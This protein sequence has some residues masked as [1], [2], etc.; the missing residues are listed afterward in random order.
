MV[1]VEPYG[2]NEAKKLVQRVLT[3]GTV[4]I[5]KHCY[6]RLAEHK[7]TAVDITNTLRCGVVTEDPE[8]EHGRWRYRVHTQRIWAVVQFEGRSALTVVTGWRKEP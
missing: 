7:L 2:R 6:D 4:E 5:S 8:L 3:D 1:P